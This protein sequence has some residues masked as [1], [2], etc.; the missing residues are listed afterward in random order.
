MCNVKSCNHSFRKNVDIFFT[1][2]RYFLKDTQLKVCFNS[3]SMAILQY[4]LGFISHYYRSL[5][6]KTEEK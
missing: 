5:E 6:G 4:A 1:V 3:V 2:Q